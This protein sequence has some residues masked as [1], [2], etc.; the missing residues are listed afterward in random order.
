MKGSYFMN[1]NLY[2]PVKV[3]SG[4]GCVI[5]NASEF[6]RLGNRCLIIT[7]QGSARKSGALEDVMKALA[8]GGV[9]YD[10]FDKVG[11]NPL[12][13]VCHWAGAAARYFDAEFI[14]GIGG[15]SPID[16]SKAAA[17]F[18][19]NEALQPMNIYN[20]S[21]ENKALPLCFIG[22][23]AGTG[24]EVTPI[25]VLTVD[26]QNIKKSI[27]FNDCYARVVFAD[28]KYTQ[29]CPYDLTVSVALDALCHTV[30]GYYATRGGDIAREFAIIAV[31]LLWKNIYKLY[32]SP[33]RT[34]NAAEREELYYGSLWA[35]L[36]L[37]HALTGFPHPAGYV[38]T[39]E[40]NIPH[41]KACAVFLSAYIQHNAP[42]DNV[43]TEKLFDAMG[44]NIDD[45]C[46]IVFALASVKGVKLTKEQCKI[47]ANQLDGR[48]NLTNA[49]NPS[50]A[51]EIQAVYENLFCDKS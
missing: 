19:T 46:S 51:M 29:S 36:T 5:K 15:G 40:Y 13:S 26:I 9:E 18:A 31:K 17:I 24:S 3:I 37:N 30:E 8:F 4:E 39:T 21:H 10:V 43:L 49:V 7:G 41:G 16:A 34:P 38:L 2:M 14:I 44:C 28:P 32:E 20:S 25:S 42:A 47:Y 1:F 11:P 22:T 23:T 45:F 50:T 48:M 35:G 33:D 12:V 27:N 6:K